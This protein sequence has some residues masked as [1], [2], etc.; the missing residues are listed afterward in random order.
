[1]IGSRALLAPSGQNVYFR[2]T[3]VNPGLA[4][5]FWLSAVFCG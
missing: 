3:R 2:L 4:Y 5:A 1:L